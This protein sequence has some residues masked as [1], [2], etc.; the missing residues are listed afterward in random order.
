MKRVL[1]V[2]IPAVLIVAALFFVGNGAGPVEVLAV[3]VKPYAEKIIAVGQLGPAQET[4][5]IAEV[6]GTVKSLTAEEGG[7]VSAGELL[8]EIENPVTT[9]YSTAST[10]YS[11]LGSLVSTS[12]TDYNNAK[13]LFEEGAISQVELTARKNALDSAVSQQKAALLQVE[14]AAENANKYKLRVPWDSLLLKTYVAPGEYVKAGQS[15]VDIGSVDGYRITAEVDE[16]YFPVIK[17]GVAVL[18]SV[19]D[20][21]TGAIRSEVDSITPRIN[22]ETGT[23]E[24]KIKVPEDFPYIASNLTVSLEILLLEKDAAIVI[25][26]KYFTAEE[27]NAGFVLLYREGKVKKEQVEIDAGFGSNVLV[28]NGLKEGDLLISPEADLVEGDSV[29]SYK[30]GEAN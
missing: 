22:K 13:T 24:I 8:L 26:K 6:S 1:L 12:R 14:I 25:P 20:S 9:E 4:T 27:S 30:E 21:N 17:E 11:R 19:G 18:I 3:E 15:L 16:K 10:E 2:A 28:L 7:T 23:F 29:K 5:L